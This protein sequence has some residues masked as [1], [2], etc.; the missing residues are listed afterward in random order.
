MATTPPLPPNI[1]IEHMNAKRK[2]RFGVKASVARRNLFTFVPLQIEYHPMGRHQE[3]AICA[4][5]T[6]LRRKILRTTESTRPPIIIDD[7]D[8]K[9]DEIDRQLVAPP[10]SGQLPCVCL[11]PWQITALEFMTKRESMQP[12][13]GYGSGGLYCDEM[14]M[15]KTLVILQCIY[16]DRLQ[17]IAKDAQRYAQPTLVVCPKLIIDNWL[18][19]I[20]KYYTCDQ[21]FVLDIANTTD[22][23]YDADI[24]ASSTDIVV[25][26]YSALAS[27]NGELG[28]YGC[29]FNIHWRRIV[30]DE[31]HTINNKT[32]INNAI[33]KLRA[34]FHWYVT[35]T[36]IRN[37][38]NEMRQIFNFI[39]TDS[40]LIEKVINTIGG[41]E[42]LQFDQLEQL[43]PL[44]SIVML[45]RSCSDIVQHGM[46]FSSDGPSCERIELD[47]SPEER[48]QYELIPYQ[49]NKSLGK[50]HAQRLFCVSGNLLLSGTT[51]KLHCKL[52][53]VCNYAKN[54]P[55]NECLVVFSGW[56]G[57][58]KG[59]AELFEKQNIS[60]A[61]LHGKLPITEQKKAILAFET[62]TSSTTLLVSIKIGSQGINLTRANHGLILDPWWQPGVEDQALSRLHRPGQ[63]RK[64]YFACITI[65]DSVD[66]K[67]NEVAQQKRKL[68]RQVTRINSDTPTYT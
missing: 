1:K 67:V 35:G 38:I 22:H 36:P 40:K 53:Y 41:D 32:G 16:A 51:E 59:L 50:I 3:R 52:D 57:V 46:Y 55:T 60:C 43:R 49:S 12:L 19:E 44:L 11:W 7:V 42:L 18:K 21:L 13:D 39:R 56:V 37:H 9:S 48:R 64:V 20:A 4:Y 14:G 61:L 29:L 54:L 65:T 47:F 2:K 66:Q 10:L 34:D 25:V 5:E 17:R 58:L 63:T 31:A 33:M 23:N 28:N 62:A 68:S 45:R 15:G 8:M 27:V 6:D 24:L 30:C 26:S